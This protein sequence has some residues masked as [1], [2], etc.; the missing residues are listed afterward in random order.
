[1]TH[2]TKQNRVVRWIAI[3]L[4]LATVASVSSAVYTTS[5]QP[6][7]GCLPVGDRPASVEV[8][9]ATL[10]GGSVTL[11][12]RADGQQTV[13]VALADASASEGSVSTVERT[14][15]GSTSLQFP[16]P[17][18]RSVAWSVATL[19]GFAFGEA[20]RT[21]DLGPGP[22]WAEFIAGISGAILGVILNVVVAVFIVL[23]GR[24]TFV[25][26]LW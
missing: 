6:A 26:R 8:C 24:E 15:N 17:S 19:E 7:D 14:I 25:R 20:G 4:V 10:D 13:Y 5:A 1:M 12:I 21:L 11:D 2:L 18:S 3:T 16:A 9:D 23:R 22:T